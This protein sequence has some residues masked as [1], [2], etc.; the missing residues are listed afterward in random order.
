VTA[1]N[2]AALVRDAV[3]DFVV[4]CQWLP[5]DR[6]ACE[7][8][9]SAQ[10]G[11]FDS[12]EALFAAV[13]AGKAVLDATKAASCLA[14]IRALTCDQTPA[15]LRTLPEC[16]EAVVGAVAEGGACIAEGVCVRGTRCV[17]DRTAGACAGTCAALGAGECADARDCA[18]GQECDGN[19]CVTPVAPGG[20]G[21]ACGTGGTCLAGFGCDS[22]VCR[23]LPG[24]NRPCRP[25]GRCASADLVC[26]PSPDFTSASCLPSRAKGAACTRPFECGGLLST[27]V[28]DAGGTEVCV[29]RPRT[30][31]CL[32]GTCDP[33]AAFCDT[34]GAAPTCVPYLPGGAPCID[35]GQCGPPFGDADCRDDGSGTQRCVAPTVAQVCA[36]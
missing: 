29:D 22:G 13:R 17:Q 21:Q 3:C 7:A 26:V 25:G 10:A 2:G 34:S 16:R 24:A 30:G 5:V 23:P 11:G 32:H 9:T 31:P 19:R 8:V 36:P 18:A 15:V 28:C 35:R 27:L 6:V 14:A 20:S 12:P 1:D 4:R 33:L